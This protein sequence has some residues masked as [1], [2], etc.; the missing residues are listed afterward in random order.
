MIG[1]IKI[2][3]RVLNSDSCKSIYLRIL[4]KDF[5]FLTL[6]QPF[7]KDN[8]ISMSEIELIEFYNKA[9]GTRF[10][11]DMM[12]FE[13]DLYEFFIPFVENNIVFGDN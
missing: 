11:S 8:L 2:G 1:K 5:P 10:S 7:E 3:D 9:T 12:F 4:V 13:T 6:S